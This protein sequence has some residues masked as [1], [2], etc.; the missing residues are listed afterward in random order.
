MGEDL[1]TGYCA[2]GSAGLLAPGRRYVL[3]QIEGMR[4]VDCAR[5]VEGALIAVPG[6]VCA[7]VDPAAA[8]AQVLG[9]APLAD[10]KAAIALAGYRPVPAS[11]MRRLRTDQLLSELGLRHGQPD[12]G[13]ELMD[14]E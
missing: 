10:L 12:T 2:G 7:K 6:V 5:K 3:F 1:D 14:G 13:R 11:G 4:S 9:S 8:T